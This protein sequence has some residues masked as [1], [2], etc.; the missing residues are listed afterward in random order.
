M[1]IAVCLATRGRTE[2]LGRTVGRMLETSVLPD[3]KIIIGFDADEADDVQISGDNL[4]PEIARKVIVSIE[5]REDSLGAKY[6][7]LAR[8]VPAD[9]YVIATD[10]CAPDTPGW[11][12]KIAAAAETIPDDIGLLY[13]GSMGSV[14][15][16]ALP[17]MQAMTAPLMKLLPEFCV[18][19]FPTW[20]HDTWMDEIGCMIG[21]IVRVPDIAVVYPDRT[22]ATRSRGIRDILFWAQFF[23]ATRPIR[24]RSA[25][26]IIENELFDAT[27]SRK[28]ALLK[29]IPQLRAHFTAR[30]QIIL[31]PERAKSLERTVSF[32]AP[33][34]DRYQR[35]KAAAQRILRDLSKPKPRKRAAA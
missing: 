24:E 8:A 27:P 20:F 3:T 13:F 32:D 35:V 5:Q 6:N 1:R 19:Y 15:E 31:D 22:E 11:D 30:N 12:R 10:D 9:L 18:P 25:R 17:A 34:D 29:V 7:R 28:R 4:P 21:R 23:E 2:L 33:A 26:V 16:S 14:V